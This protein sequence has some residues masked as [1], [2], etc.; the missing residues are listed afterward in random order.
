MEEWEHFGVHHSGACGQPLNVAHAEAR[1]RAEGVGMVDVA[2]AHNGHGL[3]AAMGMLRKPRHNVAVVHPP[4]IPPFE[5]VP[6]LVPRERCRGPQTIVPFRT[7]IGVVNAEKK[8]VAGLPVC[9]QRLDMENR[10]A[11]AL[12]LSFPACT[13]PVPEAGRHPARTAESRCERIAK[14]TPSGAIGS[15]AL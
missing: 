12:T 10:I 1:G 11:H 6:D 4:T 9:A 3:E 14:Y 5:I 8:R 2:P 15:E 13:G 7:I